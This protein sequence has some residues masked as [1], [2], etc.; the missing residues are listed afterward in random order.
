LIAEVVAKN[1]SEVFL[2]GSTDNNN[3]N[4]I[5]TTTAINNIN[6]LDTT[7]VIDFIKAVKS[8]GELKSLIFRNLTII[9]MKRY[10]LK[11]RIIPD[12]Y[13]LIEDFTPD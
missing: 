9:K 4:V 2:S 10:L 11:T 5:D 13:N 8:D 1:H 3:I 12:P 7:T 6:V